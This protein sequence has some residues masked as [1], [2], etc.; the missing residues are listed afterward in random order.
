MNSS[1]ITISP[2]V[3][4]QDSIFIKQQIG[5]ADPNSGLVTNPTPGNQI[6]GQNETDPKESVFSNHQ[7]VGLVV[8]GV[9]RWFDPSYGVEYVGPT[10]LLRIADWENKAVAGTGVYNH[11]LKLGAFYIDDPIINT[12]EEAVGT[13][14][15]RPPENSLD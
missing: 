13:Y 2:F 7:F 5:S 14:Q 15:E 3:G 1:H 10:Q 12:T 9:R 6:D 4:N 11:Q 8:G